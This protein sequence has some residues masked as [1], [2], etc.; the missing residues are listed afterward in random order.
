[1][2]EYNWKFTNE[3]AFENVKLGQCRGVKTLDAA[4]WNTASTWKSKETL[5]GLIWQDL[6]KAKAG[7]WWVNEYKEKS[8]TK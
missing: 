6:S 5:M 4:P 7:W 1:M 3:F 2:S 8:K